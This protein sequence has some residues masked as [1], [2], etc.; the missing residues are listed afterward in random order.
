MPTG[1]SF[2][3][4]QHSYSA[5]VPSCIHRTT[6]WFLYMNICPFS[7]PAHPQPLAGRIACCYV[8]P[9]RA[10]RPPSGPQGA[11][12]PTSQAGQARTLCP[13]QGLLPRPGWGAVCLGYMQCTPAKYL[14]GMCA[15]RACA[16]PRRLREK[17]N[18][19]PPHAPF[20]KLGLIERAKR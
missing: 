11:L 7:Y 13:P 5:S 18:R 10:L 17:R 12:C 14:D 20:V 8:D 15:L 19:A 16:R 1:S 3:G 4:A 2:R 9:L 6:T